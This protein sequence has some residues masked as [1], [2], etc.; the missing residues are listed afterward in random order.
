M[1][2]KKLN[3]SGGFSVSFIPGYWIS[4]LPQYAFK[5]RVYLYISEL[6]EQNNKFSVDLFVI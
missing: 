5:L 6:F 1:L 3:F 2:G 4:V